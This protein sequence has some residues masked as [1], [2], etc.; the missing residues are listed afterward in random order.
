VNSAAFAHRWRSA[1]VFFAFDAVDPQ[2]F[3]RSAV[4]P[5]ALH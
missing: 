2:Q 4:L 3:F 5:V 1:D